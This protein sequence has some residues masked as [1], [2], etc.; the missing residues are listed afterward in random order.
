MS[1]SGL[2]GDSSHLLSAGHLEQAQGQAW[3]AGPNAAYEPRKQARADLLLELGDR[4]WIERIRDELATLVQ[5]RRVHVD[6]RRIRREH[7]D[8]LDERAVDRGEG[9]GITV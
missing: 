2:V 8:R 9:V 6:D 4:T 3:P 7:V 1:S 5:L